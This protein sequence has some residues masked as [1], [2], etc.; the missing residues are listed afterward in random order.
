MRFF[1]PKFNDPA[2]ALELWE[3]IRT[4]STTTM[5]REPKIRKVFRIEYD[6]KGR[7][8]FAEVGQLHLANT[9][10]EIVVAIL[11]CHDVYLVCTPSRGV[12]KDMPILVGYPEVS[13]VVEFE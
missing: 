13:R 7:E 3:N 8:A 2:K 5:G 11:D 6:H 9:Q 4:F 1:V 10:L 12:L